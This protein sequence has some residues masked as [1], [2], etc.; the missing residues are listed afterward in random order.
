M[1]LSR[2]MALALP[3]ACTLRAPRRIACT[4]RRSTLVVR[5]QQPDGTPTS[6]AAAAPPPAAAAA[7]QQALPVVVTVSSPE[8]PQHA[9]FDDEMVAAAESDFTSIGKTAAAEQ[10]AASVRQAVGTPAQPKGFSGLP[11]GLSL[12][13]PWVRAAAV[14]G[15]ALAV[16]LSGTLLLTLFRMGRDPQKKR[17]KTIN[18]NKVCVWHGMKGWLL[19]CFHAAGILLLHGRGPAMLPASCLHELVCAVPVQVCVSFRTQISS[20]ARM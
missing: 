1:R 13:P 19:Q 4:T 8:Q 6:P 14:V 10:Q 9:A 20:A 15:A 2:S 18:K 11:F 16:Y 7:P 12:Q 17:G 3:A 5:A